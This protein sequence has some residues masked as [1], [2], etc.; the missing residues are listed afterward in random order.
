M[1]HEGVMGALGT[2]IKGLL[3]RLEDLK[4]RG[5]VVTIQTI[6]LLRLARILTRVLET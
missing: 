4:M 5:R 3:Q 2:V 6:T 1:E